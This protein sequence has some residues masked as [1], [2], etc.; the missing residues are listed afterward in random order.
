MKE[1]FYEM[2]WRIFGVEPTFVS[3][4]D[5]INEGYEFNP[6]PRVMIQVK[7]TSHPKEE[8]GAHVIIEKYSM[9]F[10]PYTLDYGKIYIGEFILL[11]SGDPDYEVYGKILKNWRA[12]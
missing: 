2:I 11:E 9:R 10:Y 3:N 1:K 12:F 8:A 6:V 7:Y 5:D 4:Y